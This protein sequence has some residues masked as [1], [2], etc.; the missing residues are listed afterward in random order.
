MITGLVH[1]LTDYDY[2]EETG[3]AKISKIIV[4]LAAD[5]LTQFTAQPQAADGYL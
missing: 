5:V 1:P 4:R 3:F 2:P